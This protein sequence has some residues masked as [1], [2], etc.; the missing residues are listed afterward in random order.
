M[1]RAPTN[2]WKGHEPM[3]NGLTKRQNDC[4]VFLV[5]YIE[6]NTI[7]PT[8][9][10][11]CDHIG[12]RS[13]SNACRLVNSLVDRGYI[14][15]LPNQARSISLVTEKQAPSLR[16]FHNLLRVMSGIDHYEVPEAFKDG[17]DWKRFRSHPWKW[18]IQAADAQAEIVW[19]RMLERNN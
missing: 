15:K 8:Y 11:I 12:L 3:Q 14:T 5:G 18:F 9:K 6:Q 7:S 1:A 10:E 4:L 17:E 16:S 13:K 2:G 19:K